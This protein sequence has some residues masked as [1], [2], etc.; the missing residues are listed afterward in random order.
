M[1]KKFLEHIK[2]AFDQD[3][4]NDLIPTRP[5]KTVPQ[6]TRTVANGGRVQRR[7]SLAGKLSELTDA[8]SFPIKMNEKRFLDTIEEAL[9]DHAFD[10]VIPDKRTRTGTSLED[11]PVVQFSTTLSLRVFNRAKEIA[12]MKGIRVKDVINVALQRYVESE[13]KR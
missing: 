11:E 1:A 13:G 5:I 8:Q 2:D 6:D 7:K 3:L 10:A 9:E 4:L 12:E